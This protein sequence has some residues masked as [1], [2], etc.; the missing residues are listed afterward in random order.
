MSEKWFKILRPDGVS[1][2][3]H[4]RW[5][6]VEP[7]RESCLRAHNQTLERLHERGGLSIAELYAHVHKLPFAEWRTLNTS[8]NKAMLKIW[9]AEWSTHGDK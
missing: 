9:F 4:I 8:E 5:A 3:T 1:T 2:Q 6:L 7:L